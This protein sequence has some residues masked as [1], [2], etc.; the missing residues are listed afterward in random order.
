M[1]RLYQD[2]SG[3]KQ[4]II[5]ADYQNNTIELYRVQKNSHNSQS[6]GI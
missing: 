3:N 4:Y 1:K 2:K 5:K 6:G